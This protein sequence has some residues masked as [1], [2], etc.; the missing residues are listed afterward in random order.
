MEYGTKIKGI[1][2]SKGSN[3]CFLNVILQSFWHIASFR[4][5]FKIH[6]HDHCHDNQVDCLVCQTRV[7]I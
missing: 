5:N 1:E 6:S 7:I 2:N 3:N 4:E